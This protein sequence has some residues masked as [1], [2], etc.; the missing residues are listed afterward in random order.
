[1]ITMTNKLD[2]DETP[3]EKKDATVSMLLVRGWHGLLW[4]DMNSSVT[5]NP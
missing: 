4:F 3:E 2:L 1:M 5:K